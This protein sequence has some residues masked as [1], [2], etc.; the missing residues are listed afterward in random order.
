ML[1]A[2]SLVTLAYAGIAETASIPA[3]RARTFVSG[4]KSAWLIWLTVGALSGCSWKDFLPSNP[5]LLPNDV[6]VDRALDLCSITRGGEP[7]HLRI[8]VKPPAHTGAGE[9]TFPAESAMHAQ[10]EVWWL[11]AITYR[12]EIHSPAFSQVRIVNGSV[13]E[14]H[15]VGSFYPRWLQNFVDAL[16]D[17]VPRAALLRRQ[18]GS[19]PVSAESHACIA[20]PAGLQEETAQAQMCFQGS[21]PLLASGVDFTR[22]VAFDNYRAFGSQL[23]PRTLINDLPA[24][25]LVEGRVALLEPLDRGTSPQL[26]A[27]SF[28]PLSQQIR[29]TLLSKTKA[30]SLLQASPDALDALGG[31]GTALAR[32]TMPRPPSRNLS[33]LIGSGATATVYVRTDRTGRVREAYTDSSDIYGLRQAAAARAL[34]MRFK[35]L[36]VNGA[37]VQMEAPVEV[38]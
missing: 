11:N 6:A 2:N 27:S 20:N 12:T 16:F 4:W 33:A 22:Y 14:E 13:V 19:I 3:M 31:N 38:P 1:P 30:E 18:P 25:V 9:A 32:Q 17:P 26:K 8:E 10:I 5:D 24:N 7:F 28:T 35:P 21:Q 15:D 37:A 23:I 34:G 36:M 29:T